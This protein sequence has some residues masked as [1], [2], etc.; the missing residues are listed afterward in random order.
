M[1]F[2]SSLLTTMVEILLVLSL[3]SLAIGFLK[4]LEYFMDK[5]KPKTIT[6]VVIRFL[7]NISLFILIIQFA[8]SAANLPPAKTHVIYSFTYLM[9]LTLSIYSIVN[10]IFPERILKGQIEDEWNDKT[11]KDLQRL[12]MFFA[13][14]QY[15]TMY[16]VAFYPVENCNQEMWGFLFKIVLIF[17]LGFSRYKLLS[18]KE[19]WG[20]SVN[21]WD[22]TIPIFSIGLHFYYFYIR[23]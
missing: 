21:C 16:R 6:P 7:W 9:I 14:Y 18:K 23:L 4:I 10:F 11:I 8:V 5:G 1:V 12:Y 22:L 15:L 3:T 20:D 17:I 13:I 2:N 19:N